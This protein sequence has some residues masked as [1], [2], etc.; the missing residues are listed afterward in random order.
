MKKIGK[1]DYITSQ[2]YRPIALLNIIGKAME[3]IIAKRINYMAEKWKLL[4][5]MQMGG[6]AGRS[7]ETALELLTEQVHII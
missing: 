2:T 5:E 4:P 6:R 3:S 7:T 1:P